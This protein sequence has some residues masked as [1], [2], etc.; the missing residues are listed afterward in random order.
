MQGG[1]WETAAIDYIE[2]RKCFTINRARQYGKTTMMFLFTR[3]FFPDK[4]DAR[5][6]EGRVEAVRLFLKEPNR[7]KK[8][9][10]SLKFPEKCATM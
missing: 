2:K 3:H 6:L 1:V 4:E 5:T 7:W 8:R 10:K 9:K